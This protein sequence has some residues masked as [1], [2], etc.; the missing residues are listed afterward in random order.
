MDQPQCASHLI[1]VTRLALPAQLIEV[2]LR[3]ILPDTA[4]N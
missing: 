3:A 4:R 2:T 1:G